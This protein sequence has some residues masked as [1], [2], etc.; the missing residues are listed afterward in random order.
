MVI[1]SKKDKKIKVPNNDSNHHLSLK[2]SL[3]FI[4]CFSTDAP[5]LDDTN[6]KLYYDTSCCSHEKGS[7]CLFCFCIIL[8]TPIDSSNSRNYVQESES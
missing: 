7:V 6:P 5:A 4:M 3:Y 8:H 2:I 1:Q